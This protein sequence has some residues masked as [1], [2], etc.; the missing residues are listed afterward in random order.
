MTYENARRSIMLCEVAGGTGQIVYVRGKVRIRNV[1]LALAQT[2]EV[3]AHFHRV[4]EQTFSVERPSEE[5]DDGS[6]AMIRSLHYKYGAGG[7][8]YVRGKAIGHLHLH[9]PHRHL[10]SA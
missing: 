7:C 2:G 6:R 8:R 4:H 10:L 3:E 1:P 9:Y 5:L